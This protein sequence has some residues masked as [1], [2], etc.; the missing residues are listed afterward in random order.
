LTLLAIPVLV[1]LPYVPDAVKA[2]VDVLPG[3]WIRSRSESIPPTPPSSTIRA[4]RRWSATVDRPEY[5]YL[6]K[7]LEVVNGMR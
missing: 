4:N 3:S 6:F 1:V 5:D 2:W 7:V